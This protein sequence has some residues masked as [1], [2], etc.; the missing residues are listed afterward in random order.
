[1]PSIPAVGKISD[2]SN[3]QVALVQG[4]SQ[5]VRASLS[6]I[7]AALKSEMGAGDVSG[8]TTATDGNLAAFDGD[9]LTLKDSGKKPSDF[10]TAA[11]GTKADNA[12]PKTDGSFSTNIIID[13]A[14]S[15]YLAV[16]S[17]PGSYSYFKGMKNNKSRWMAYFGDATAETGG[18]AGSDFG[19]VR[20]ADDG[21][22]LG[23]PFYIKRSTGAAKFGAPTGGYP[24]AE[25]KAN[26]V[27]VEIQGE[28]VKDALAALTTKTTAYESA[29]QTITAG[30]LLTLAHGLGAKPTRIRIYFV[31]KTAEL[32]YSV[33]D[34]I[35]LGDRQNSGGASGY[36]TV[37]KADAT[38]IYVRMGSA[39]VG[40][41][42]NWST[43]VQAQI[44][45]ANWKII[46]K[47]WP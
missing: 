17:N 11:Q 20:F 5:F 22:F 36:G 31:C 21:T 35:E 2:V 46:V 26:F 4:G 9:G 18:N 8:P 44:T 30:G 24:D 32:G 47:A 6:G 34:E 7:A 12:R 42:L 25:G 1:M 15:G 39:I 10:A 28:S 40:L 13:I 38:S 29:E 27:D 33:G 16:N 45:N 23:Y 37:Y 19:I 41:L 14:A 3:V 43:G